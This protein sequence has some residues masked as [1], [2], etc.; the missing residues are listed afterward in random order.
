MSMVEVVI[1]GI[2]HAT[3]VFESVGSTAQKSMEQ[4]EKSVRD[5]DNAIENVSSLDVDTKETEQ[6]FE[7]TENA[8]HEIDESIDN[9]T[10]LEVDT[11]ATEEALGSVDDSVSSIEGAVDD[12]PDLDIET[13][14]TES[15]MENASSSIHDVGGAIEET[16]E[17]GVSFGERMSGVFEKVSDKWLEITA[18][19]GTT[20][21]AMEGFAR[22]QGEVNATFDRTSIATGISSDAL[23][24]LAVDMSDTTT[25]TDQQAEAFEMLV[26]RGIDTE[27]QFRDIIPHV[28]NLGT[29]T[30]Q[31]LQPALESADRML[32]PFGQNLDDLGDNVDQMTRI[33]TQTDIPLGTLE[34]NLGRVPDELAK[35]EFGLDDASAGIEVF[36]DRGY[37]GQEAVRNF[38]RAVADSEGDMD[39]FL[40]SIG[41]TNKEWEEYQK[42]VEPSVGLTEEIAQVNEDNMT[43]ME[44]L[45]ENMSNLMVEYGGFAEILGL[46]APLLLVLGPAI[47]GVTMATKLF[48]VVLAMNPI[49]LIITAIVA[50]IAIIVLLWKN[51]DSVSEFLS[52]SWQR[53]KDLAVELFGGLGEYFSEFWEWVSELFFE[54]WEVI[55]EFFVGIWDWIV[56]VFHESLES[57]GEFLATTWEWITET[58]QTV[59]NGIKDFFGAIWEG[60]VFLVTA[61]INQVKDNIEMVF[62]IISTI[63]TTIWNTIKNVSTAVWNGIVAVVT[64]IINAFR[65]TIQTVFSTISNVISTVWNAV[66]NV[67][68]S[69]WNGISSTISGIVNG[70]RNTVSSVFNGI[71]NTITGVWNGI[72]SATDRVWQGIVNSIK[73][74]INGVIGAINGMLGA[75]GNI[76]INTPKIP[77][78][79]PK[80]GGKSMSIGF[81]SL[82][83]I[84]SLATGGVVSEPTLA[85]VGDAGRGN[86]EIVAP[87]KMIA[88][89]VGEELKKILGD[90]RRN[91]SPTTYTKPQPL[92]LHVRLGRSEFV[93]FVEDITKEQDRN[94]HKL[95]KYR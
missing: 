56:E 45:N 9:V 86:P 81:P 60:I 92:V 41:L 13:G 68:S 51:W 63:I 75:L 58:I 65:N 10:D 77:S 40:D 29:A 69:V 59:W 93:T 27:E 89:I 61:Y 17:K 3:K 32:K 54:T 48:N 83:K 66:R 72:K 19:A 44:K 67:S 73:G 62:T 70:I 82:P 87:Q 12:I 33:M 52:E 37:N 34:R 15:A 25:N 80:F 71:R 6:A 8:V 90:I 28:S 23:R 30:G 18:V 47:K 85:M 14:S 84:P 88:Q 26:Q 11:E 43:V 1:K 64:G 22:S 79:V 39:E 50:L 24:D 53:I 78:W 55:S 94:E 46:I 35:L 4:A 20:G 31:D 42:Q 7:N 36:R 16:E 95:E 2:D 21:L 91:Y 76:R 5:V 38:R 74:A 49:G 57:I